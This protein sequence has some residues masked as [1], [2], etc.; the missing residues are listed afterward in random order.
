MSLVEE[1]NFVVGI[2]GDNFELRQLIGQSLGAP[3]TKSD[4][5]FFNRLDSTLNHV[6]C[7]ITPVDYPDKIKPFLQALSISNIHILVID[8]E[9]GLNAVIGETLVGLDLYHDLFNT[10]VLVIIDGINS[11]TEWKLPEIKTKLRTILKTTSLGDTNIIEI[12]HKEDYAKLKMKIIELGSE[13]KETHSLNNNITT[14]VLIDHVFPVKGI[15]TVILGVVKEGDISAGQMLELIGY[16]D[17]NKKVII[18]SIQK[19]DRVFKTAQIGDR[20]GLALKGNISPEDVSRSNIL[21]SQG[22][23]V[24]EKKINANVYINKFYVP[25]S[26]TVKPSDGIQYFGMVELKISP[27]KFESGEEIKPGA[28]GKV[29]IQFDKNLYHDGTGLK[30]IITELNKFNGKLRII[31][32]FHQIL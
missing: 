30:G 23:F 5:L 1:Q 6:F 11:K 26:G 25:N 29:I 12:K 14:K 16:E 9:N 19:H 2:F 20:V 8:L 18:R 27:L 17:V 22:K 32:H 4:L 21:A 3:G 28:S 24:N 13:I 10:K 15:G 31:G 7:A